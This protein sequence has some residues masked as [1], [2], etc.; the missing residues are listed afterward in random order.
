[1]SYASAAWG[2]I[3]GALS[4]VA[5]VSAQSTALIGTG[6]DVLADLA[7]TVFLIWRFRVERRGHPAPHEVE[8]RAQLV[9]ST[10]L[11]VVGVGLAVTAGLRLA[12]GQGAHPSAFPITLA[13]A[14]IVVLP[15]LSWWKY[16]VAASVPSRALHTDAHIG[17]IGAMTAALTLVGL[18]VTSALGWTAADPIAAL[19]VA[20][21]AAWTG[22]RGLASAEP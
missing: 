17:V 22:G 13:S 2:S 11:L 10:C 6:A 21:I 1:M 19:A 8:R 4:I 20:A 5:G 7:S 3:G 18:V 14:S 9:A 16:R 12:S 15:T